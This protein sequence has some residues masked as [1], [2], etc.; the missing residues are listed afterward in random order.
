M[1]WKAGKSAHVR[2]QRKTWIVKG[3]AFGVS[4]SYNPAAIFVDAKFV[5]EPAYFFQCLPIMCRAATL[6]TEKIERKAISMGGIEN[7]RGDGLK[8]FG[9]QAKY[10]N[11]RQVRTQ[12]V[13]KQWFAVMHPGQPSLFAPSSVR[14]HGTLFRLT[15]RAYSRG[16]AQ[17]G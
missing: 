11:R 4:V 9:K 6:L 2:T 14:I 15:H 8:G 16:V 10:A 17:S 12:Q 7:L 1:A 3:G 13:R 5:T